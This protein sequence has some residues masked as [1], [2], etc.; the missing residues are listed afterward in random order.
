MPA[1]IANTPVKPTFNICQTIHPALKSRQIDWF[2]WR[3]TYEGGERF[4]L[5]YLE[6]FSN[7]E[8]EIEFRQRR[9]ISY[10]PAFAR[11]AIQRARATIFSR[12]YEIIRNGGPNS[13]QQAVTGQITGVDLA[14]AS[15]NHFMGVQ[16]LDE[17]L[18]MSL[19]GIYVDM[20]EITGPTLI[21]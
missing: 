1:T 15:M 21:R 3:L 4:I 16:V 5:R 14:G 19:V 12:A 10:C 13:Y 6:K 17:L 20:P 2:K 11:N 18:K 8:D 9:K 7:R